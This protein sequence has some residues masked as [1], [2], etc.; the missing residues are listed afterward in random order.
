MNGIASRLLAAL[1]YPRAV[2]DFVEL[3]LPLHT[4][5]ESREVR[6]RV[7]SVERETHDVATLRL[8]PNGRFRPHR[9]GQHVAV[10]VRVDGIRRTRVFSIAS[11][12]RDTTIALTIK[13]RP[14][15][16]VTPVLVSGSLRDAVVTLGQPSGEFVL[17][18]AVP[19]RLLLV[20]GGSGITPVMSML[21]TLLARGHRGDV[22][23]AHWA[24]SEADVIYR[25][26]LER[27]ARR[28][29]SG[30][31]VRVFT[32]PFE[33]AGFVDLVP[34]FDARDTWACGPEPF[35]DVVRETFGARGAAD[36]V[37]V[38]R[39]TRGGLPATRDSAASASEVTFV[40][41]QRRARGGG[42][43]LAM[44]EGAGLSPPSGCRMGICHTCVCRKVSG[45][46]R[47]LRTGA[48]STDE[49]VDVQLCVSEPV[50]PV[51][52]DL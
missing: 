32:G 47:D 49:D 29:S 33:P 50:G 20:S 8:R 51:E 36:R 13:A 38:E 27:I 45:V 14:G 39:F 17:P 25:S 15:G 30:L 12:E 5:R 16:V 28:A 26:E 18:E 9:A 41:S 22:V 4:S 31:R 46:T 7:V 52:I 21:R 11:A 44:A 24:R 23:F 6:A 10:T 1:A 48:L 2:D 43:L 34:D 3:A 19:E 40:R 35:L 37:R 42:P